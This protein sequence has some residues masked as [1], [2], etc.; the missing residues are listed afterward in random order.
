[1]KRDM[2]LVREILIWTENNEHGRV[3][4]NPEIEGY[5]EEEIG[6]HVYIMDQAGLLKAVDMTSLNDPSP[7]AT[8]IEL[9]WHGH[10]FLD[11]A[12]DDTIW[13]KA[14][15]TLFK[16]TTSI[17]FDL[18]LEWLKAEGRNRLGLHK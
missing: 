17:T 13:A 8:L 15:N 4:K 2:N 16:T 3:G 18:L 6:Y 12:K 14:K 11:A 5:S 10:E 1:M 7:S 9:T